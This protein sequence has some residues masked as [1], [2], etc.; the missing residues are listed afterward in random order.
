LNEDKHYRWLILA[1]QLPTEEAYTRV[2][3]WRRLQGIGAVSFRNA[4]YL[5]PAEEQTQEDFEW[6]LR[7]IRACRGEGAV[8]EGELTA[9]S[10]DQ[11]LR[12]LFDAA[13]ESDYRALAEELK[14]AISA[15]PGECPDAAERRALEARVRRRLQEIETIDFFD[16]NGRETV[17]ALLGR[18]EPAHSTAQE[19]VP[20]S[21]PQ[22]PLNLSGRTWVTRAGVRVDRMAS[23]WL[24]R[25][26]IDPQAQFKFVDARTYRPRTGEVRFDMF[27]AEY[28]HDADRCTFEVLM[29]LAG[30][31]DDGL[32]AI[33]EIVHD[34]DI[35]DRKFDR[36]EAAGIRQLID[37]IIA[38]AESDDQRLERS[39]GLFDD[40]YRSFSA[41][42]R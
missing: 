34:L 11:A 20:M 26:R 10:Y 14:S 38:G 25:R 39:A 1:F 4:V 36:P 28:T 21:E 24:I 13:R 29:D 32:K 6:I 27:E 33:G 30:G 35:K 9:S 42:R 17:H 7:E 16:A 31:G 41:N 22:S 8:F 15:R 37:G 3:I 23:A 19:E 40:L 5:L 2:K 18:L 12:S